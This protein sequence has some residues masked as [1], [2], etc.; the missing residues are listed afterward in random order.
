MIKTYVLLQILYSTVLTD[1]VITFST[2][3]FGTFKIEII[4]LQ[5]LL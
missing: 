1:L 4:N 2:V 5:Y 3:C